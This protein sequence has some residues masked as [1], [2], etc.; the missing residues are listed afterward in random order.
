MDQC[1]G[2]SEL[3]RDLMKYRAENIKLKKQFEDLQKT[4]SNETITQKYANM[5]FTKLS[6]FSKFLKF[7]QQI[8][9]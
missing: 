7:Y 2:C 4:V 6:N 3:S 8:H 1:K 5:I 9:H